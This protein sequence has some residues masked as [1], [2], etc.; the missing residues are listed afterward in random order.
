MASVNYQR[1]FL[2]LAHN[3][4]GKPPFV[5]KVAL[6]HWGDK[7]K[8][9]KLF[10]LHG[11]TRNARDFDFVIE[12]LASKYHVIAVD[13]VGRGESD[14]VDDKHFYNYDTYCDDMLQIVNQMKLDQINLLGTS[15]GGIIGMALSVKCPGLINKILLND[16]GTIVP[17]EALARIA[18][19][20]AIVPEFKSFQEAKEFFKVI[21]GNFGI[22][23]EN[24]WDHIVSHST[25][26]NQA[27]R[28]TFVYDPGI[29][30]LFQA[31]AAPEKMED[32]NMRE[33][34]EEVNFNHMMVIHAEKSDILLK[35]DV[36]FMVKSKSNIQ[37]VTFRGVGHA[38]ALVNEYEIKTVYDFFCS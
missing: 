38:P 36:D 13:V 24:H 17:K 21:L 30:T 11:L 3:K 22:K 7:N 31:M 19:Y 10:C 15:M 35:E 6:H 33:A 8:A 1:E 37:A 26:M 12:P 4:D 28:L 27:G 20:I 23:E 14:W 25:V 18:R 16:I 32:V 29:A 34:W 5:Y 2:T 9:D